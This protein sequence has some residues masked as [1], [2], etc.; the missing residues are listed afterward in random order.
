MISKS[1]RFFISTCFY[2]RLDTILLFFLAVAIKYSSTPIGLLSFSV[3][4]SRVFV[5]LVTKFHT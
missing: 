5:Q 3:V 2:I 1:F 4:C